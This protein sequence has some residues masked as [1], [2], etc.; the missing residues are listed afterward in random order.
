[1]TMQRDGTTDSLRGRTC[2][3]RGFLAAVLAGAGVVAV[4]PRLWG[5]SGGGPRSA[6]AAGRKGVSFDWSRT[7]TF[8][9]LQAPDANGVRLPAGFSSR[10]VARSDE[11][12]LA[13]ANFRWHRHP[14]GGATFALDDGGW[15]YVS[16]SE[17]GGGSGGVSALR[18]DALANLVDAY[19]ICANTSRNC[20]GGPTPWGTWLSCE[21]VDEED[22]GGCVWEC[23]PLGFRPAQPR[24]ALG[25]FRHEAAAVDPRDGRVYLT[26]DMA[27]GRLYRFTPDIPG[28]LHAGLLE[29]S[30]V[31]QAGDGT[32][33]IEW[34]PVPVPNP[35]YPATGTRNQV[36]PS[37]RFRGAEGIWYHAG[38]IYFAT[39]G[40]DR[41]W[42]YDTSNQA[43]RIIY[44]PSTASP[45][46]HVDNLVVGT[47]GSIYVAEDGGDMQIVA[48]TPIGEVVP[49]LQI[50]GQ[51]SSELAGPAFNPDGNRLYVSSMRGIDAATHLGVT[52]E[53]SG[54]FPASVALM[55]DGFEDISVR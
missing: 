20:A 11:P 35:T 30:V 25:T 41:I 17:M 37:E 7:K 22:G 5:A 42:E 47:E 21:E 28:E 40:D 36:R 6:I 1:M 10:V 8:G 45:L 38:L 19:P 13:G 54:P 14:D 3:R 50:V 18:F 49:L 43:L 15:V 23:D 2:Q 31:V 29:A 34:D 26:E 44:R 16:N 33:T 52:Y 51:D 12:A 48:L 4:S 27:D 32:R 55:R 24:R 39:K 9:P 53:I 46:S